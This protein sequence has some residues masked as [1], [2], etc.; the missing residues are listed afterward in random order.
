MIQLSFANVTASG[1]IPSQV[2]I[3]FS[4]RDENGHAVVVPPEQLLAATSIFESGP[5][6]DGWEEIDYTETSFFVQAAQMFE[7]VFVLDFTNSM[8]QT[9]LADGRTG[10]EAML[11]AFEAAVATLPR[12]D[13]I[14]VVEFHDR[15]VEPATLSELTTDRDAILASV[16]DFSESAF[17]PGSSRMWDSIQR[18]SGIFTG[19]QG[20]ANVVRAIVFIF[21]GRDTSSIFSR[22]DAA[23]IAFEEEIQLYALGIGNVHEEE[24]LDEMV[25]STGGQYYPTRALSDLPS[26]LSTLV[27]D[28]RGQYR[29]S[30]ITL[31]REGLYQTRVDVELPGAVGSFETQELDISE[32]YGLDNVGRI[33]VDPPSLDEAQGKA[34][35]FVRALHLPRNVSRFRFKLDTAKPMEVKIVPK[36]D[37]GLLEG[38]QLSGPDS[39]GYTDASSSNPLEFGSFG[40]LFQITVTG[41]TERSLEVPL[42]FDSS[43]YTAGKSLS[44]PDVFYIGE[45]ILSGGHIA[46]RSTRDVNSEIYSMNFDGTEQ[47][48]ITNDLAEDFLAAWSSDGTLLVFDSDRNGN[49]DVFTMKADGTGVTSLTSESFNNALP[50]ASPDGTR[51]VF[52]SDRDGDREIYVMNI[53]GSEQTRLTNNPADDWWAAWSSDGTRVAFTSDRDGNAEVYVM[54]ADGTDQRNLTN[55]PAGDFRPAWSPDGQS[56]TFHSSRDGNREV[57]LMN[58][59]GTGQ[60]N[61]TNHPG[62]DWYPAW[63]P[64]GLRIAYISLRDGNREIYVMLADGTRQINVTNHPSDDSAP[65][66]GP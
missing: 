3:G 27:N 47:T 55:N 33:S 54:E 48:N 37:G 50:A 51:V 29:V 57:Y 34:E 62:D 42:V 17:E 16:T 7:V 45:Q 19:S 59:A 63:A 60:T 41:V 35:V 22:A 56:I 8:A 36:S 1:D 9:R 58:A 10:I 65:S 49:R 64:D 20:G 52:N 38:W 61:L 15:S 30:Y 18:A 31:R 13:R 44:H 4:L 12:A 5:G 28:L 39:E 11:D 43:I 21:D 40:L 2:Q 24:Q 23:E 32:F 14:G 6:T 25:R 66:W 26:Q 53:D 46:F